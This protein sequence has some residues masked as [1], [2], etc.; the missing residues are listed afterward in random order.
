[1]PSLYSQAL[2]GMPLR[3]SSLL[4]RFTH[5]GF[6]AAAAVANDFVYLGVVMLDELNGQ[7]DLLS[8]TRL[9]PQE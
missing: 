7:G 3:L 4:K 2:A 9:Y 6:F 1:M 8:D 5:A